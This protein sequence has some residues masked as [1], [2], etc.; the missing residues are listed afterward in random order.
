MIKSDRDHLILRR[1]DRTS[2]YLLFVQISKYYLDFG[3]KDKKCALNKPVTDKIRIVNTGGST[4][5]IKFPESQSK[6][7]LYHLTISPH[8]IKLKKVALN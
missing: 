4:V 1:G 7:Q 6:P 2:F 5:R 3:T 8:E